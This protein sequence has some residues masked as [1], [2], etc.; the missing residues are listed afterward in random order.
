MPA[1]QSAS[2]CASASARVVAALAIGSSSRERP[3]A[4]T[5][6]SV[7]HTRSISSSAALA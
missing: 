3:M 6:D 1:A 7:R 5:T 4:C 2:A